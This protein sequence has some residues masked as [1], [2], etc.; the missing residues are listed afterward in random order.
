MAYRAR[1]GGHQDGGPFVGA[2][3]QNGLIAGIGRNAETG[4][5][6][7]RDIGGQA[8][9]LF[10]RQHDP[11]GGGAERTPPLTVPD[12][13]ALADARGGNAV[14]DGVDLAGA[15]AVRDDAREGDLARQ[16]GT[17]LDVGGIDA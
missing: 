5:C 13:D 10:R 2:R 16:A 11:V 4:A 12:P 1:A 3:A 14:A 7:H 6:F 9:R 15:I 17:A 8:H